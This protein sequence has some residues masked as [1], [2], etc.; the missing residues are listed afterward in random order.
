MS[1][2]QKIFNNIEKS[3]SDKF[4]CQIR[5]LSNGLKALLVSDPEAERSSAALGVNVGSFID[6]PDELGL[7]HFCEH[8]LFMGTEKYPSEND[9]E[10]YLSKNGGFSNAYTNGDKTVF[11]FDVDNDAFEGA[12]DRFA[13]FFICPLFN[14]GSVEREINS[15][16]SEFSKN[17]NSDIW[18]LFHFFKSELNKDCPFSK[19]STGNKET[20]NFPD[21]RER[22]LKMYKK[23]YSSEIMNLVLYSKLSMDNLIKLTDEYFTLVPKRDNFAK[24][25]YDQV[26]PYDENNLGF[27]YKI[28]PVKD[29]DTITFIWYLPFNDNYYARPLS[30]LSSLFGHEGENTLTSSLKR[31]SFIIDLTTS[32]NEFANT[33]SIFRLDVKLTK[34]GLDN[35]KE[36]ILRILKYFKSIQEKP[37][38]E[39]YF[40]EVKNIAQINFDFRNKSKPIDFAQTYAGDLMKYKPE[41]IFTGRY[42]YKEYN[43]SLI[44]KY[45]NLLNMDNLNIYFISKSLEKECNLIEKIYG[46]KYAKG[47]LEIKKEEVDAYKCEHIFDYPS[48][49]KFLPKKL[50]IFPIKD[51]PPIYPE[52]IMDEPNCKVWF[53]QD[54]I[55]KLPKGKIKVQFKFVEELLYNSNIKNMA[56]AKLLKKI[57]KLEL[58]ELIY[59]ASEANVKFKLKIFYNRLELFIEGFNDSLKDGLEEILTKI[60]NMDINP[61]K[62]K[63]ILEL[64]IKEFIKKKKNFFYDV[65]YKVAIDYMKRLLTYPNIDLRDLIDYLS[66]SNITV[67]DLVTFKNSMLLETQV[68]WLIQGNLDKSKA[69][70]IVKTTNEIL[71]IDVKKKIMKSFCNYRTVQ[72]SKNIN[73]IYRFLNPNKEEKDSTILAVFQCCRSTSEE[74]QYFRLLFSFLSDKFYDSLRTKETLGYVVSMTYTSLY[75]ILH[76]LGVIQSNVKVPEYCSERIRG[77][78]KEKLKEIK[79]ISDEDFNSRVKSRLI[80][81]TK[82]DRDLSEQFNRNWTEISLERFKFNIKEENAEYLKL[83]TKEGFI[84]F[85]EKYFINEI[86]KLDVEYV[87]QGHNEENEKKIGEKIIIDDDSAYIKKRIAFEKISDFHDCNRLYPSVSSS[88]RNELL[89]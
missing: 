34:K 22:L 89:K 48:E 19:F 17:K 71:N 2:N 53:L 23:Y 1:D 25:K 5:I 79:E 84:K 88:Y 8:L 11:Y 27:L 73:Y 45:L 59:L 36:V 63:E 42:L 35:Y 4:D 46:T 15:I 78:F 49:N 51:N 30:F 55:F 87:S 24:P 85:Y 10:K 47:K 65:S 32:K 13:Q 31:D 81:E 68:K 70:E 56:I 12:V 18:R 33:F 86:R 50:D 83:C 43:E 67:E 38:N 40:Q 74:A 21:I 39:R 6:L 76:M 72:L 37:I 57:I 62:H 41:D 28:V 82:K 61:K 64:Q 54:N 16:D 20:L 69:L 14:E 7:A 66:N 80:T 44:K 75:E 26:K 60:K 52:K 9:Y 3:K 29:E 58:N 77:F